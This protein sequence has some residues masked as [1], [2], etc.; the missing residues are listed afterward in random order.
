MNSSQ[1]KFVLFQ[2]KLR[3]IRLTQYL[4]FLRQVIATEAQLNLYHAQISCVK[5]LDITNCVQ[6]QTQYMK[7]QANVWNRFMR[8]IIFH[9]IIDLN[10]FFFTSSHSCQ[11]HVIMTRIPINTCF[12]TIHLE[13][14]CCIFPTLY[15]KCKLHQTLN[16]SNFLVKTISSQLQI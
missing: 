1:E 2:L 12:L 11:I 4:Q 13:L 7:F 3:E 14:F 15:S 6:Q 10:V 9:V 16:R 5:Q 8:K